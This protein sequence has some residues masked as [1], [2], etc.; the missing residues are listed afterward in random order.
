M[1]LLLVWLG[2]MLDRAT[3]ADVF[4]TM[5]VLFFIGNEGLSLLE[6]LGLMGVKYPAF[7][8][9]ALEAMKQKGDE[10]NADH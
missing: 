6:D 10:G 5:I 9:K 7:L 4:R 1:I 3:G 8:Q 2:V